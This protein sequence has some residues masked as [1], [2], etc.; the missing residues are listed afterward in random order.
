MCALNCSLRWTEVIKVRRLAGEVLAEIPMTERADDS[1]K[2][3]QRLIAAERTG[4]RVPSSTWRGWQ[5]IS[6]SCYVRQ[7]S[8][9][10]SRKLKVGSSDSIMVSKSGNSTIGNSVSDNQ[11]DNLKLTARNLRIGPPASGKASSRCGKNEKSM[12]QV[13]NYYRKTGKRTNNYSNPC[14]SSRSVIDLIIHLF[15]PFSDRL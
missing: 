5:F 2:P 1:S 6:L 4:W 15:L 14:F 12:S 8:P 10:I 9:V 13:C 7:F 11:T 3:D